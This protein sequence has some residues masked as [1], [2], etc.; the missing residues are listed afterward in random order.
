MFA[1]VCLHV[2]VYDLRRLDPDTPHSATY[3]TYFMC[4]GVSV[5]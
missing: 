1:R 4:K 5:W 2:W 3:A